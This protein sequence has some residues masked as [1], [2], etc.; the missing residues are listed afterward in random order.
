MLLE[1]LCTILHGMIKYCFER[2]IRQIEKKGI[3]I[4][5]IK[6]NE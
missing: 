3:Y 2:E 4:H 5:K 6:K 1:K